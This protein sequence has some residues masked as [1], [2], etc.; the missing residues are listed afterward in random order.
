M[1]C[2]E[3]IACCSGIES[4]GSF[5]PAQVLLFRHFVDDF[6]IQLHTTQPRAAATQEPYIPK[7]HDLHTYLA[8]RSMKQSAN[9]PAISEL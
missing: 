3:Q 7:G 5:S 1:N 8:N 2:Y 9:P 6:I 4:N